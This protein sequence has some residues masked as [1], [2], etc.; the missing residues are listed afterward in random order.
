M[1]KAELR[2][3]LDQLAIE[4]RSYLEQVKKGSGEFNADEA[5]AKLAEFDQRSADLEKQLAEMDKPVETRDA[6]LKIT[7]RDFLDA[8]AEKRSITIGK[9]GNINQVKQLFE[10]I[11]DS[12]D[13]LNAVSYDYGPNAA[14][15]IPV[16]E[17]G[18][19]E[20]TGQSEGASSIASD[21]TAAL[22]TTEIQPKAYV[23]VLPVTAEALQM[24]SVDIES[25]LPELF[26][27][28]FKKKMHKEM[29]IGTGA[30]KNVK[31][32]FV[33]AAA[34][35]T[36]VT[37]IAGSTIKPSELAAL[38]LK[39]A[40]KDA[41]Y[42]IVMN[43]ATYG[44]IMANTTE[45]GVNSAKVYKETLIR[46]KMI[47]GVKVRLDPQCP[48]TTAAG[49][50]LAVAV[51]LSRFHFGVAGEVTITPIRVPGDTKTYFQAEAF[52]GGK[53]VSD[54]DLFSLAVAAAT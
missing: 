15:N 14:T 20:P 22:A 51:P 11:A 18:L 42:E 39:V 49:S 33:S 16:L 4:R 17:P 7:N 37:A 48:S 53:Q 5:T 6:G 27:K 45:D 23:E 30:N 13:I 3:A 43:S 8:V 34:N 44:A 26:Q 25:K 21:S 10:T 24:G 29:M 52:F 28:V 31:G 9:N 54:S 2:A 19:E 41:D 40:N 47:E 46:D 32:I 36:G 38:A 50:V 12:N 35:T 1:T